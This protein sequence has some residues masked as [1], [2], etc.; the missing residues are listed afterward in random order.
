MVAVADTIERRDA[1]VITGNRLAVDDARART[2]ANQRLD[3]QWEAIGEIIAGTA[4]EPH[5]RAVLPGDDPKA[6]VLDLM[7]PLAA[8]R[9]LISLAWEARRDEP[10]REGTHRKYCGAWVREGRG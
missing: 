7:Q 2:Q 10:G 3:N 9:Q 4:V 5:L 6:I 1:I 8:G